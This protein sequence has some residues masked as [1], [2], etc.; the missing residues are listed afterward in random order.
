[1]SVNCSNSYKAILN[2]NLIE[3]KPLKIENYQINNEF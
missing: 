2:Q 1:M 3:Y